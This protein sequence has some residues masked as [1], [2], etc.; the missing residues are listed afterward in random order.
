MLKQDVFSCHLVGEDTL[1]L[2]CADI[3]LK[4]GHTVRV[5]VS[6]LAEAEKWARKHNV[7]YFNLLP[8]AVETLLSLE[9]DYLFSV[10]NSYKLSS[11]LLKAPKHF[12]INYH[13]SPLPR[14]AGRYP[15]SWAILNEEKNYGIT[16]H[17][18]SETID[19]GDILL[20]KTFEIEP[21]ATALALS[22][23]CYQHAIQEFTVLVN[24]LATHTYQRISQDLT[25]RSYYGLKEKP[26]GNAWIS[27]Y[28][29]AENIYTLCRALNMGN[30]EN[31]LSLPKFQLDGSGFVINKL[32]LLDSRS[33]KAPGTLIEIS[34]NYWKIATATKDIALFEL[35]TLSGQRCYLNKLVQTYLLKKGDVL[36][37]PTESQL[38]EFEQNSKKYFKS[39]KFWVQRVKAFEPTEISFFSTQYAQYKSKNLIYSNA[40]LDSTLYEKLKN[41]H[42]NQAKL[43]EVLLAMWL[44]YLYRL[45]DKET[46]T[47]TLLSPFLGNQT[48]NEFER[49]FF[50]ESVPFS[51]QLKDDMVFDQML[52]LVQ[53]EIKTCQQYQSYSQDIYVR[54]PELSN[55]SEI[56]S[57]AVII[58]DKQH[59]QLTL[60]KNINFAF[61]ISLDGGRISLLESGDLDS[62]AIVAKKH[63]QIIEHFHCLVEG[64]VNSQSSKISKLSLMSLVEYKKIVIEWNKTKTEYPI[65]TSVAA[66][67]EQQ[68]AKNPLAVAAVC[69]NNILTYEQLNKDANKIA[70]YLKKNGLQPENFVAVYSDRSIDFATII[71]AILKLGAAYVP[72]DIAAPVE[73]IQYI[74]NDINPA[75]ILADKALY[76]KNIQSAALQQGTKCIFLNDLLQAI[77]NESDANLEAV[78]TSTSE[79]IAYAMYTS[80]TTGKPKGIAI[81]QRGIIRL[82]KNTNYINITEKDRIGNAASVSFDAT[83]FEIWGALLNGASFVVASQSTLLDPLKFAAF[84]KEQ[85]IS[86]LFLTVS[87]FHQY[88]SI[89]PDMFSSLNYLLVGG[90]VLNPKKIKNLLKESKNVPAHLLNVYGPTEN[91][92]FSTAYNISEIINTDMAIPIGKPI[93][94]TTAY[95]LD[96]NLNPV[97]IGIPGEL[98]VGGDGV[99]NCYINNPEKT[100]EKFIDNCFNEKHKLYKTGDIV[101]WLPDG[102]IDYIGRTDN[103]IKIR[104]FRVE[105]DTVQMCLSQHAKVDECFLTLCNDNDRGKYLVAY[106]VLR[107]NAATNHTELR[108]FLT[109]HLPTYMIPHFFVMLEQLP[110]TINGK[111]DRKALPLPSA[112]RISLQ[113]NYM[114]PKT[115]VE[116]KLIE[117]WSSLFSNLT[118]GVADD[119]FHLGGD[120]LLLT[121][122]ILELQASF[123]F[124][125]SLHGFLENPT[126]SYV[127]EQISGNVDQKPIAKTE[128]LMLRDLKAI[129]L[130]NIAKDVPLSETIKCVLLTGVTGFLGAHVLSDLYQLPKMKIYCLVRAENLEAARKRLKVI[131]QKYQLRVDLAERIILLPGNLDKPQLGLSDEVF[132]SL[133]GKLDAIFHVGANVH[134][135]YS[136]ETLREANVLGTVELI[137]LASAKKMKHFYYVSTL[138]AKLQIEEINLAKSINE[139]DVASVINLIP[140]GYNQTKWV[141][142]QLLA[143]A[144]QH[145]QLPLKIYRPGWILGQSTT[146]II[147]EEKNHLLLLLKGCIQTGF[148]PLWNMCLNI[149]P[150]DFLS[151]FIVRSAL[152]DDQNAVFD[153]VNPHQITWIEMINFLNNYGYSIRFISSE[154]WMNYLKSTKNHGAL[155][156]LLPLYTN[157][158]VNNVV[159]SN[160]IA[161]DE[162]LKNTEVMLEKLDLT[163]PEIDNKLL[164]GYCKFLEATQFFP[165][166]L[167]EKAV[168][169]Y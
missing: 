56:I 106:V 47:I 147:S 98:H 33:E 168:Q 25:Q 158:R 22:L 132:A 94:N 91:T 59:Q 38:T 129:S 82:V 29:T 110:L 23:K 128:N 17:I 34:E 79:S 131:L 72:V 123:D 159:Y 134:H 121:K 100:K 146:G 44:I 88:V 117:I 28:N 3:L 43:C 145:F 136:Y 41:Q 137:K 57:S 69:E 107:N 76:Q 68:V 116:E 65:E 53:N 150:V 42:S 61:I 6:P 161:Y 112:D 54:Y 160:K 103:Q 165:Q 124:D 66:L 30:Y 87:L 50:S 127:A 36:I 142:E 45:A 169:Y 10:V 163:C 20:Q 95:I 126:I 32:V 143:Y 130:L 85:S 122:F 55:C 125:L 52:N 1:I 102:N 164:N 4:Q 154:Q 74:L 120:S 141:A 101:K 14:Y 39:E 62:R 152:S 151:N 78:H 67:F 13:N 105:L 16:W 8:D 9:V 157:S 111:I 118:I 162:T 40:D 148:A 166:I 70:N 26:K 60:N 35:T 86:I 135:L 63:N 155:Y 99:A 80:G 93:A 27:W 114:P 84:L 104:G 15:T 37:S 89:L 77:H 109:K 64:I 139:A 46:I 75:Y 58:T 7:A 81:P 108:N 73:N 51:V 5:I 97:P 115:L 156:N 21:H 24:Q 96:R 18:M 138:S 71:L 113:E 49:M 133:A 48:L 149:L 153:L 92:T 19:A 90:D 119:F 12:A 140:D 31:C 167:L 2:Q 83:T 11:Q 144:Q